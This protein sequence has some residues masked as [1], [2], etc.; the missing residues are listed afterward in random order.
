MN[1]LEKRKL[2]SVVENKISTARTVYKQRR[3]TE[4]EGLIEELK[5]M[6]P[7]KV[8]AIIDDAEKARASFFGHAEALQRKA[9][10]LGFSLDIDGNRNND[11]SASLERTGRWV[12]GEHQYVYTEPS[13]VAHAD[14]TN[15]VLAALDEL[16]AEYLVEIWSDTADMKKLFDK[17]EK[18]SRALIA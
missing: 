5:K 3:E 8:Q 1:T 10:A 2:E 7:P 4:Y 16:N 17:F 9:M 14:E 18:D 11:V 15:K 12:N 6:L 13:I